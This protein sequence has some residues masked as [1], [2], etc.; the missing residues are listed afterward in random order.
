MIALL[1]VQ[2][3]IGAGIWFVIGIILYFSYGYRHSKL[4]HD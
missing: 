4:A 1:S 3:F 2:T